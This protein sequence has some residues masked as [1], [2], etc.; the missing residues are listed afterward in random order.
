M[1][2]IETERLI[3]RDLLPDDDIA[4]FE[5]D[6]N[7]EVH[8]YLGG[9]PIKMIDQA[10]EVIA[11]IRTQYQDNGIGHWAVIEKLSNKFIGWSGLKYIRTPENN[12]INFMIWVIGLY[13]D[14]GVGDMLQS[15]QKP[16]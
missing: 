16:H 13:R 10:R 5:L 2:Y 8:K 9:Q 7:A 14:I 12:R 1:F 6:S 3:L 15:L 11:G 4:M